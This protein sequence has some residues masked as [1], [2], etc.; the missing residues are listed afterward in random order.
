MKRTEMYH[1]SAIVFFA[2]FLLTAVSGENI[3]HRLRKEGEFGGVIWIPINNDTKREE[4]QVSPENLDA[5]NDEWGRLLG[6]A[7]FSFDM[8]LSMKMNPCVPLDVPEFRIEDNVDIGDVLIDSG[9]GGAA[10]C[11]SNCY[12]V[13]DNGNDPPYDPELGDTL[14]FAYKKV[15]SN[16]FSIQSRVCAT[17]CEGETGGEGNNPTYGRVGVMVREIQKCL[18]SP[19]AQ[20]FWWL[21]LSD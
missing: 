21:V 20:S 7:S 3:I 10:S 12:T 5:I 16:K 9:P 4:E 19:R 2:L 17:G 18:F 6:D 11:G 8:S 14:R 13:K 1:T 15:S